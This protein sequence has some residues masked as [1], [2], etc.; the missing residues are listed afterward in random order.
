MWRWPSLPATA[1]PSCRT[2]SR[3][4][5]R[6]RTSAS[7]RRY[8]AM[9]IRKLGRGL[10]VLIPQRMNAA[11]RGKEV[12]TVPV[13]DIAPNK[14]QPRQMF[15]AGE[16]EE[17]AGSIRREGVL[18]PVLVRQSVRGYELIAGE[19]RLR[20]AK[21]A[22]LPA[23]PAIVL[24]V[25]DRK[26]Q[27]LALV[28]NLQ[29]ED[30]NAIEQAHGFRSL[31]SRYNLTQEALADAIGIKRSTIANTLR[32]LDLPEKILEG[33]ASD[34]IS[35][36]HAKVLLSV[37]NAEAQLALFQEVKERGLSV[38]A[39]EELIA[40]GVVPV[41]RSSAPKAHAEKSSAQTAALADELTRLLGTKVQISAHG[42][43][44]VIHIHFFSAEDFE[45]LR[46]LFRAAQPTPA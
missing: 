3:R 39:L 21:L 28:E 1:S 27:E 2:T 31:M 41:R 13:E 30:L 15:S 35:A 34:A 46:E 23:V 32:L 19:R 9:T 4:E 5:A 33:L 42:A 43:R 11:G 16:L 38:R 8:S 36:G 14:Y 40:S 6:G 26:A 10:D 25:D 20:A 18:Q 12:I 17:L 29:R 7:A 45:R 44:G 24:D 22:N 37:A